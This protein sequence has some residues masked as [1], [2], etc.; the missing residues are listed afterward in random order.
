M[1]Y[2]DQNFDTPLSQSEL[3][4]LNEPWRLIGIQRD[5]GIHEFS[6]GVQRRGLVLRALRRGTPSARRPPAGSG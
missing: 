4:D 3:D 1:L 5:I 6:L 2:L